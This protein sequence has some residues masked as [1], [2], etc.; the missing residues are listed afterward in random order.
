[1]NISKDFAQ[2][3]LNYLATRPYAEVFSLIGEL[4]QAF[5]L[6]NQQEQTDKPAEPDEAEGATKANKAKS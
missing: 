1:M 4:Q 2:A 6:S 5:S 3:L